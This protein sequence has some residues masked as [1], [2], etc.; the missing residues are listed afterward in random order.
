M[1]FAFTDDQLAF[2]DAVADLLA[3][4]CPPEVVRAAWPTAPT[5]GSAPARAKGPV[6]MPR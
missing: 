4:E 6:P 5:A 2:R 1:R 3:E